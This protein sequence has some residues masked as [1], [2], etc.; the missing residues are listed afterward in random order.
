M[1]PTP[2]QHVVAQ[3]IIREA[4]FGRDEK[5]QLKEEV[6]FEE[7]SLSITSVDIQS[8]EP[9][10]PKTRESLQKSVQL[11]IEITTRN[12]EASA[13][14]E[15]EREEQGSRGE[16]SIQNLK[17][18]CEAE[19]KRRKL[20][21]LQTESRTVETCGQATAEARAKADALEIEG[22]R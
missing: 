8:V 9:V 7:N 11:A 4:V 17:N 14:H 12:Q 21:E 22:E 6:R 10:D 1:M 5:G 18:E 2:Q 3:V 13:R 16:L 19:K 20:L 15:A